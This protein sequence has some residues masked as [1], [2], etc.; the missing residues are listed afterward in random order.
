MYK[1]PPVWP[2]RDP[3]DDAR[4]SLADAIKT[5]A[6]NHG[7]EGKLFNIVAGGYMDRRM[8][9]ALAKDDPEVGRIL[10]HTPRAVSLVVGPYGTPISEIRSDEE[11]IVYADID[12][13]DC[14]EPR[15]LHDV[16]GYYNR[17]DI[18]KLTVDRSAN[19]P[20]SFEESPVSPP[21]REEEEKAD[22]EAIAA[23][24]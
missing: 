6:G 14:V 15:Q 4:H 7:F 13:A 17:F 23:H 24:T 10:D 18:F 11:G 16:V 2:S 22:V 8:R 19:R 21:Q 9:D 3:K 20:I 5:R 12:V 1:H